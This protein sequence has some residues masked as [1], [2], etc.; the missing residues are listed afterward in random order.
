MENIKDRIHV[1]FEK[2]K[3]NKEEYFEQFYKNN[4]NF[5]YRI[6]FSILK[7]KENSEDV[8]QAIFE[9][10]YKM[11]VDNLASNYESSWLYTVAKNEAI[12]FIRKN[13]FHDSLDESNVVVEDKESGIDQIEVNEDYKKMVNKLNKKQERIVSL[14]VVS[15]FTFKEI[16]QMLSMPTATVQWYYYSSLKSLKAAIGS[17]A[18]FIICTVLGIRLYR[19]VDTDKEKHYDE[20]VNND[21]VQQNSE[22]ASSQIDK[23]SEDD[24]YEHKGITQNIMSDSEDIHTAVVDN[25]DETIQDSNVASI[26]CFGL[27]GI[28]LVC[29]IILGILFAKKNSNNMSKNTKE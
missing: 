23:S 18:M 20:K 25:F 6:C 12:Q 7:D 24:Y 19:E 11:P 17:M 5:V 22:T 3:E 15:D 16:G 4:Y 13:K 2:L 1:D 27:A 21:A 26:I 28:F 29:T 8:S 9:K 10:L 14:K